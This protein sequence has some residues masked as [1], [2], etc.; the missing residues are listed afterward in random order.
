MSSQVH[1]Y[2]KFKHVWSLTVLQGE[3]STQVFLQLWSSLELFQ[4][5]GINILLKLDSFSSH[6][7]VFNVSGFIF[8]VGWSLEESVGQLLFI[9]PFST[10]KVNFGGCGNK[11]SWVKTTERDTVNFVWSYSRL[12]DHFNQCTYRTREQGQTRVSLQLQHAYH[13]IFQQG[14][15]Q[16]YQLEVNF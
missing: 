8:W 6:L 1:I 15:W 10:R 13:G 4:D 7:L 2:L 16:R 11:I 9:G 5:V 12:A 3:A 14:R